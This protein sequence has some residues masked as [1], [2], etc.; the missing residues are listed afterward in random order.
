MCAETSARIELFPSGIL[1]TSRPSMRL[2][3]LVFASGQSAIIEQTLRRAV[4]RFLFADS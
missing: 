2:L 3:N 4:L 1:V